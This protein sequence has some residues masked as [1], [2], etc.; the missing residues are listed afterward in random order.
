MSPLTFGRYIDNMSSST[1]DCSDVL[2]DVQSL[3][4]GQN[5]EQSTT[6]LAYL[7]EAGVLSNEVGLHPLPHLLHRAAKQTVAHRPGAAVA[8]LL[9]LL[10]LS[11]RT[12]PAMTSCCSHPRALALPPYDIQPMLSPAAGIQQSRQSIH[13]RDK[14]AAVNRLKNPSSTCG[15]AGL[16]RWRKGACVTCWASG[17]RRDACLPHLLQP[18]W[19]PAHAP[20]ALLADPPVA[21]GGAVNV[22]C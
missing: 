17:G 15:W 1:H 6:T 3:V 11:R 16:A 18:T 20:A 21:H 8:A 5:V 9:L 10:L 22:C 7:E 14:Q 19:Q 2:P 12:A 13:R 4:F